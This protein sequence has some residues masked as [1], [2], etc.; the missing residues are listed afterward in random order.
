MHKMEN[1][2]RIITIIGLV[3]EGFAGLV[4]GLSALLLSMIDK[5]PGYTESLNEMAPDELEAYE[6]IMGFTST[7]LVVLAVIFIVMFIV[8]LILFSKL[9]RGAYTEEQAR[10]VYL[11]QAIWG[12]INILMNSITGILY[13]ISGIQGY[14]GQVDRIDTREGI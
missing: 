4:T 14:N 2:P 6:I 7:L 13:L 8:N 10:K 1:T 5:I 12:G 9:M 3:F 11:Y